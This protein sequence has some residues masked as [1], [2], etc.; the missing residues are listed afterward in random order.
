MIS[1]LQLLAIFPLAQQRVGSFVE[2]LNAAMVAAGISSRARQAA[3][4][5]CPARS[6]GHM[7]FIRQALDWLRAHPEATAVL[8]GTLASWSG[9]TLLEAV[10]MPLTWTRRK[11]M[12]VTVLANLILGTVVS[13]MVWRA[14]EEPAQSPAPVASEPLKPT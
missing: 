13:F 3:F 2:P 7:N 5:A 11:A 1:P 14:M 8:F 9:A 12:Q 10:F 4:L 6:G